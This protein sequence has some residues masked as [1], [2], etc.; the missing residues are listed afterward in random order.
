MKKIRGIILT[1]VVLTIFVISLTSCDKPEILG[2]VEMI[3]DNKQDNSSYGFNAELNIKINKEYLYEAG[4]LFDFENTELDAAPDEIN[5]KVD[6]SLQHASGQNIC[7]ASLDFYIEEH[8]LQIFIVDDI[9]FFENIDATKIILNLLTASGFVDLPVKQIFNGAVYETKG[10]FNIDL[11]EFDLSWFDKFAEQLEKTFKITGKPEIQLNDIPKTM[12]HPDNSLPALH[13]DKIKEQ[14]KKKLLKTPGYRYSELHIVI[15]PDNYLNILAARE[16]GGK[17]LL[18]P[19]KLD[20]DLKTAR[21]EPD[22]FLEAEIIPM[23]YIMELMGEEVGWDEAA[24]KPFITHKDGD[25]SF[26][27]VILNSRS[28]INTAQILS[29]T[30][31]SADIIEIGEYIEFKIIRWY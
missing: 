12:L 20:A 16:N 31:Y 9:L 19:L 3:L 24:K 22:T 30:R 17:E 10:M 25:M 23:R 28:Y 6:G 27:A 5:I 7:N 26:N 11:K 14:L 18:E 29:T 4:I 13:F 15:S 2:L 1:A 8:H 21:E